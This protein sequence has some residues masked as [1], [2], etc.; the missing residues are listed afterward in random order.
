MVR[1][2]SATLAESRI[3]VKGLPVGEAPTDISSYVISAG[4]VPPEMVKSATELSNTFDGTT[5]FFHSVLS[6]QPMIIVRL[7]NIPQGVCARLLTATSGSDYLIGVPGTGSTTLISSGYALGAV[8]TPGVP[9]YTLGWSLNPTQAGWVC[10][11]GT[12]VPFAWTSK[13]VEPKLPPI[14]GNV[15]ITMMF[16]VDA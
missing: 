15:D 8:G 16:L 13:T 10:K 5:H 7:T 9:G 12:M 11:Y 2:L 6:G 1:Q 3:L 4:A 14:S